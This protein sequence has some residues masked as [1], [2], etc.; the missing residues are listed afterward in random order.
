MGRAG[1]LFDRSVLASAAAEKMAALATLVFL[2]REAAQGRRQDFDDFLAAV[3]HGPVSETD[4]LP[5]EPERSVSPGAAAPPRFAGGG[6]LAMLAEMNTVQPR[7][8]LVGF[9]LLLIARPTALSAADVTAKVIDRL[10][11]PVANAVIDVYWLKS[12][13]EDDVHKID[14]AK[15]VSDRD[16]LIQGT[17]DET[18]VPKGED[19][20]AEVS[21]PGYSGY[22]TDLRPEFVLDREFGAADVRRIAGLEGEKQIDQLRELL[23]GDFEH[24]GSGL[25]ELVFVQEYKFRPA[26]RALV[27]DPKVGTAAG[28]LLAFVGVPEDTRLFLDHAPSP[29][30]ELFQD[31]WAYS[32]A[33][34]LL[35]PTTEKE[36]TFLRN[37]AINDYD[38]R[39]VDAG[40]IQTLKLIAS[41]KS[42][43]VLEEV[44]QKN[45]G[46]AASVE[47]AVRYIE[48]G[49]VPLSDEDIVLAGRKVA[50]AIKIGR[51]QGNKP[52]QYNEEG[53]KALVACEFIAGRDL[54]VHT[55]TFHKVDGQWRLRGVRETM[56]ALLAREPE[57]D[58]QADDKK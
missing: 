51:W 27:G 43:Q 12:V 41:P 44:G 19:I 40:G 16:G 37:C 8:I 30:R 49:P 58:V 24:F 31:R 17:Y 38:D 46:R 26:L 34:V 14:L 28:Q 56:Q 18:S 4:R 21:K 7:Y 29:K 32:I 54:L 15:L 48:A 33:C 2:R 47:V 57:T 9:L 25:D 50:Q 36:W 6:S 11:R 55:A 52:P 3:R 22:S 23:A 5:S 10:G 45:A 53:D 39:W 42:K 1:R 20:L 35:E 13:S